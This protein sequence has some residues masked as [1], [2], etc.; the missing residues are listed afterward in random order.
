MLVVVVLSSIQMFVLGMIGEYLGRLYIEA[1]RRPL[2]LVADVAGP[3]QGKATLGFRE[4]GMSV[5]P[6]SIPLPP[7][8]RKDGEGGEA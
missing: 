2:Y 6:S 3:V 5:P 1:K 8:K 7:G 4:K